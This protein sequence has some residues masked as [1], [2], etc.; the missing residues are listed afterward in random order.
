MKPPETKRPALRSLSSW[1]EELG[2]T[3]VTGWRWRQRGWIKTICIAG[4]QY[5][6]EEAIAEFVQR[7]EAG[8]FAILPKAPLH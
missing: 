5:I 8:E 2:I 7:A 4:R 6:S 3:A 1:L